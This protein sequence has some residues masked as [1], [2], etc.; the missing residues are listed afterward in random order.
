MRALPLLFTLFLSPLL[1]S[2]LASKRVLD[3]MIEQ[4]A[5]KSPIQARA[6]DAVPPPHPIHQRSPF[7]LLAR[8][9]NEDKS[10]QSGEHKHSHADGNDGEEAHRLK[11]A[12]SAFKLVAGHYGAEHLL[13]MEQAKVWSAKEA[14]LLYNQPE[15]G[16]YKVSDISFD[17]PRLLETEAKTHEHTEKAGGGFGINRQLAK[18]VKGVAKVPLAGS[19]EADRYLALWRLKKGR[20]GWT[21]K[22]A[23]SSLSGSQDRRVSREKSLGQKSG[24]SKEEKSLGASRG[25]SAE[26][27]GPEPERLG[28]T[29]IHDSAQTQ[30]PVYVRPVPKTPSVVDTSGKQSQQQSQSF[31]KISSSR[32]SGKANCFNCFGRIFK[33][34][35]NRRRHQ[36]TEDKGAVLSRR[37]RLYQWNTD[38][39]QS[40]PK[41]EEYLVEVTQGRFVPMK[42]APGDPRMANARRITKTVTVGG[43]ENSKTE[44]TKEKTLKSTSQYLPIPKNNHQPKIV[45]AKHKTKVEDMFLN[46]K[47]SHSSHG[48]DLTV[49]DWIKDESSRQSPYRIETPSSPMKSKADCVGCFGGVFRKSRNT[50]S[51][52][53]AEGQ[54]IGT[55]YMSPSFAQRRLNVQKGRKSLVRRRVPSTHFPRAM[56]EED[57]TNEK[58]RIKTTQKG[59]YH[60]AQSQEGH[61][62]NHMTQRQRQ[63]SRYFSLVQK[64]EHENPANKANNSEQRELIL[65][66]AGDDWD[67][68]QEALKMNHRISEAILGISPAKAWIQTKDTLQEKSITGVD[69]SSK[70]KHRKHSDEELSH[71]PDS[72]QSHIKSKLSKSGSNNPSQ[73]DSRP[74]SRRQVSPDQE[75]PSQKG[76]SRQDNPKEGGPSKTISKQWSPDQVQTFKKGLIKVN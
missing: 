61:Y 73:V 69:S 49:A 27:L 74:V 36:N 48:H 8:S 65:A 33:K 62:H 37:A 14:D 29:S 2:S 25:S 43:S 4:L 28:K 13:G 58:E 17:D 21:D 64:D 19:K 53:S 46:T 38:S 63:L 40:R 59:L 39:S 24:G 5:P 15:P 30:S 55:L 31:G 56:S 70:P 18:S 9:T 1:P 72:R 34:S 10:P 50:R 41:E 67:R 60:V 51:R 23:S 22:G 76:S 3:A 7:P 57:D 42:L 75:T 52:Q 44:L 45:N 11:I 68:A 6:S 26:S 16:Q 47:T 54:D 66:K 35:R 71:S 12:H 20:P 32:M